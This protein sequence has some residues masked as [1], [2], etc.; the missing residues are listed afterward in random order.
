[1]AKMRIS[2]IFYQVLESIVGR[3]APVW[4]FGCSLYDEYDSTS[5][6]FHRFT[7]HRP[8]VRVCYAA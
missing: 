8:F 3:I 4:L 6:V 7:F 5:A 2:W 1:M